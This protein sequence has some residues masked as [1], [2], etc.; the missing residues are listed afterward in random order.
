M[1][2]F[3]EA[4]KIKG[5][6]A[7]VYATSMNNILRKERGL[8]FKLYDFLD[9]TEESKYGWYALA[10]LIDKDIPIVNR[11]V[12]STTARRVAKRKI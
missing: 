5:R 10:K 2:K 3:T 12:K 4:E 8:S 11:E 7:Y 6:K 9:G 1:I